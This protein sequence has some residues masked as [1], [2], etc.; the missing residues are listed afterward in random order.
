MCA[1]DSGEKHSQAT[2]QAKQ[3]TIKIQR[4]VRQAKVIH[5]LAV[6]YKI[7]RLESSQGFR[8]KFNT[9]IKITSSQNTQGAN[10][11]KRALSD[12]I[13]SYLWAT[14]IGNC[15]QLAAG[16]ASESKVMHN[17]ERTFP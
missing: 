1:E 3:Y 14:L 9:I 7:S 8:Q 11:H 4:V 5:E 13:T 17:T 15:P 16:G 12:S 10:P 6:K 2:G